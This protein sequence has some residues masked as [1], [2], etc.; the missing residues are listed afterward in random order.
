M[1]RA[2]TRKSRRE[3]IPCWTQNPPVLTE[4]K[5]KSVFFCSSAI[6]HRRVRTDLPSYTSNQRLINRARQEIQPKIEDDKTLK[7]TLLEELQITYSGETFL[8]Y[9]TG[10]ENNW[11]EFQNILF[12]L[13][14]CLLQLWEFVTIK[15][16]FFNKNSS[17]P[18]LRGTPLDNG[19]GCFPVII[20]NETFSWKISI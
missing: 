3:T 13:K 14:L 19:G 2:T 20:L 6:C 8:L 10:E 15:R 17:L 16:E 18:L 12:S 4:E 9:D 5:P 1:P 7:F 11:P